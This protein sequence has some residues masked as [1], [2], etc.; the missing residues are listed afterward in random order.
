MTRFFKII[1]TLEGVSLLALLF[2]AM[3]LKYIWEMPEAV[4]IVGMAHG[5]LFVGYIL[6]AIMLKVEQ[7][8]PW[9]KFLII[10]AASV[11]P[12]GTFYIENKYFKAKAE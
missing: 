7:D 12:F 8:W 9:K 4:R 3:P 5:L 1:A 6:L 2:I 10:C 11:V